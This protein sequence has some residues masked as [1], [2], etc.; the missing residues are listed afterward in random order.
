METSAQ[1]VSNTMDRIKGIVNND[2]KIQ[3][4]QRERKRLLLLHLGVARTEAFRLESCA[5][6]EATFRMPDQCGYQPEKEYIVKEDEF[7]KCYKTNV[8]D[9]AEICGI[10]QNKYM[11]G[12]SNV[13]T[14]ISENPGRFVCNYLYCKSLQLSSILST[15]TVKKIE[16][17]TMKLST[18]SDYEIRSLFLHVPPFE[19]VAEEQQLSYVAEV[20]K[21]L[22]LIQE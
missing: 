6:N 7:G 3:A 19:V 18:E 17:S 4:Q 2:R 10:L 13:K 8:T 5:Y 12:P 1:G 9:L 11:N 15:S 21:A 20:L 22:T 14:E 16:S